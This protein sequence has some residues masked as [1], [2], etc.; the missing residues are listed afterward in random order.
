M[1]GTM[2]VYKVGAVLAV[3]IA[4][5]SPAFAF[6]PF[7]VLAAG[8]AAVN[9]VNTMTGASKDA[10][11]FGASVSALSD[12]ADEVGVGPDES[13]DTGRI[14]RKIQ[15]IEAAAV[16]AG[17]TKAEVEDIVGDQRDSSAR[18]STTLHKL[19]RTIR[20]GKRL[21]ALAGVST[22][23]AAE[24]SAV[25]QARAQN[26]QKKILSDIQNQLIATELDR[27]K[28]EVEKQKK[29]QE[30]YRNL[31]SYVLKIAPHGD[32]NLFPIDAS[33]IQKAIDAYKAYYGVILALVGLIFFGRVVYCQFQLAP[34]EKYTDLIRD[35][36]TCYFLM[37]AFPY[38]F[39]YMSECSEALS[40]KLGSLLHVTGANVPPDT[41]PVD[42]T[43]S[44]WWWR[45]EILPLALYA[46]VH[47][48]FNFAVSVM[49]TLGPIAILVGTMMNFAFSLPLYFILLLFVWIWPALWNV[50][51]YF[52]NLLWQD[53]GAGGIIAA[54]AVFL[55]QLLSPLAVYS[56]FK[57][58]HA[59][60][61]ADGAASVAGTAGRAGARQAQSA[62][63]RMRFGKQ[64]EQ[65]ENGGKGKHG[66]N[67]TKGDRS[68]RGARSGA[69][70]NETPDQE[71]ASGA[72]PNWSQLY[73]ARRE[74]KRAS[75]IRRKSGVLIGEAQYQS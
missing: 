32:L 59:G 28:A 56:L 22:K 67:S 73:R 23:K 30:Q 10:V 40:L 58:T 13:E 21:V 45:K 31:R 24:I 34:A 57:G 48:V 50:L 47:V 46:I 16:E 5:A 71:R 75:K 74:D 4:L 63:R 27:K 33:I 38:V 70:A 68:T 6:D 65:D 43:V 53:G 62:Y 3:G 14:A 29:L 44:W 42:T 69:G 36:F 17:Y 11:E 39:N 52:K 15:A 20:L 55:F 60:K 51:G 35:V 26:D 61:V 12:L 64:D 25:E 8:S 1:F 37:L 72:K 49:I 7:T 41:L 66:M 54:G 9:A 18:L 19:T 2:K